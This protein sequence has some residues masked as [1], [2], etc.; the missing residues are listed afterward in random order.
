MAKR[1]TDTEKWKRDWFLNLTPTE[2]VF[3]SYLCDTCSPGGIWNVSWKSAE[4]HVGAKLDRAK[5]EKTFSKQIYPLDGGRKWLI[6]DFITFQYKHLNPN[7]PA[8]KGALEELR[9]YSLV[10]SDCSIVLPDN[11][12][13]GPSEHQQ[14]SPE[15]TKDMGMVKDMVKGKGKATVEV[16]EGPPEDLVSR[17]GFVEAWVEWEQYRREVKKPLTPRARRAQWAMLLK[18][19]DPVAVINKSIRNQWQ[20]LFESDKSNGAANRTGGY[21]GGR[22]VFTE[23][24]IERSVVPPRAPG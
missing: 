16:L 3:W 11:E 8:H 13:K 12:V 24:T 19:M 14:S 15:G 23:E 6:L 10:A 18:E 5:I 9:R 2:K 1:F 21:R 20:G 22:E 4:F 7:N 17:A